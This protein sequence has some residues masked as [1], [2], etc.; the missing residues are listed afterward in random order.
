[1]TN[2][3]LQELLKQYPDDARILV[4]DDGIS[5][6]LDNIIFDECGYDLY[7]EED[8]FNKEDIKQIIFDPGHYLY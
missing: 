5:K 7:K 6:D 8:T 2:K 4:M 1:M 3:E